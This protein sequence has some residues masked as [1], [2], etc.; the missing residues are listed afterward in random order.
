MEVK[1]YPANVSCFLPPRVLLGLQQACQALWQAPFSAE[2]SEQPTIHI[3]CAPL[4]PNLTLTQ[5]NTIHLT[6]AN[7]EYSNGFR[8]KRKI[9]K[10]EN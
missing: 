7:V 1:G 5:R 9:Q 2:P 4:N 6:L 10:P 3:T 8:N